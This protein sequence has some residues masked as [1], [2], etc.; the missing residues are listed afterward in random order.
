MTK[1]KIVGALVFTLSIVLAIL[2]NHVN[3]QSKISNNL[4]DTINQQ[5]AFTRVYG[6]TLGNRY[7]NENLYLQFLDV[8]L[9]ALEDSAIALQPGS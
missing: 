8:V 5:K 6:A 3:E 1:I 7:L 2:F 4:L 9:K